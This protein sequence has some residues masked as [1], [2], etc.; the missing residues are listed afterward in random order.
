MRPTFFL[1]KHT[2]VHQYMYVCMYVYFAMHMETIWIGTR[3]V[4]RIT[5]R[6]KKLHK[7]TEMEG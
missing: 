4:D 2:C 1:H 6:G 7:T 5:A 3:F